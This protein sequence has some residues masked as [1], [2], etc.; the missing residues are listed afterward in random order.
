MSIP[1]GHRARGRRR[2]P[3]PSPDGRLPRD[4]RLHFGVKAPAAALGDDGDY[5]LQAVTPAVLWRKL[6][7]AWHK[8]DLGSAGISDLEYDPATG[9]FS[10]T[11]TDGTTRESS[12]SDGEDTDKIE[13]AY[14]RTK[15]AT[16]PALPVATAEER[17]ID[18][19]VPDGFTDDEV[20][21]DATF[22]H[23]W[24][25]YRT[26][27]PGNWSQWKG[28]TRRNT[29]PG[30]FSDIGFW[31]PGVVYKAGDRA[32]SPMVIP[33]GALTAAVL[34]IFTAKIAH[35]ADDDNQ[36]P[37]S[38][39]WR[40]NTGN[41][42]LPQGSQ[43]YMLQ[44][45]R[46]ATSLRRWD[47]DPL[48]GMGAV[49]PAGAN[50]ITRGGNALNV[51][52]GGMTFWPHDDKI[53]FTSGRDLYRLADPTDPTSVE[54]PGGNRQRPPEYGSG[55]ID[56]RGAYSAL[57]YDGAGL[58]LF[59]YV[60]R[61]NPAPGNTIQRITDP[62]DVAN[63]TT[64]LS[65]G[66][67]DQ[68]TGV[69]A[70]VYHQGE[71]FV[72]LSNGRDVRRLSG[73]TYA[74]RN[75]EGSFPSDIAVNTFASDGTYVY[76]ADTN[77]AGER[78]LFRMANIKTSLSR[79]TIYTFP[80]NAE[81]VR[82]M[83]IDPGMQSSAL[84]AAVVAPAAPANVSAVAGGR[85]G[86]VYVDFDAPTTGTGPITYKIER[87]TA[88]DFSAGKVEVASDHRDAAS[89][90]TFIDQNLAANTRYWWR[91]KAVGPTG[92]ESAWSTADDATTLAVTAANALTGFQARQVIGDVFK[93]DWTDPDKDTNPGRFRVEKADDVDFTTGVEVLDYSRKIP[94]F[95]DHDLAPDSTKFFRVRK[96]AKG[97]T[98]P[99]T[100]P[101]QVDVPASGTAPSTDVAPAAP[102]SLTFNRTDYAAGTTDRAFFQK[103][104]LTWTAPPTGTTPFAYLVES[105]LNAGF[106]SGVE[107]V[108]DGLAGLQLVVKQ[109]RNTRRFYRVRAENSVD[110]GPNTA[111][112]SVST[113]ANQPVPS[114]ASDGSGTPEAP[115]P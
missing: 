53:Y 66:V 73:S 90:V 47:I 18:D 113:V 24:E 45:A 23:S 39:H 75:N 35:T 16:A 48:T 33:S 51:I 19:V 38:T 96:Q 25:I 67:G 74:T 88:A 44:R 54:Y 72:V 6:N 7:A 40:G 79:E 87:A 13:R 61:G 42:I 80:A 86:L 106:T 100:T 41:V 112:V 12:F 92:L 99:Y 20:A 98:G 76:S 104:T 17:R 94:S 95:V 30:D 101:V 3:S 108:K 62:E 69:R 71:I 11:M 1:A 55:I 107:T 46:G 26:G 56:S 89:R 52:P 29:I 97:Q 49:R 36:P 8:L 115:G 58:I 2:G 22:K 105:A 14:T 114:D 110:F 5:Y 57:T 37:D 85:L 50:A 63:T 27:E 4:A 43:L 31:R 60:S 9:I 83:A 111:A 65:A 78:T 70:A 59:G 68:S 91:V 82:A 93:I 28:P 10:A 109:A 64:D 84:D 81:E 103:V 32:M 34:G 15:T 102:A 21:T 77:T